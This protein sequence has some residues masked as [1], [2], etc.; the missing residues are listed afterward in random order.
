MSGPTARVPLALLPVRLETRFAGAELLVRIYP[1]AIHVD[2]H[3]PELTDAEA[4]AGRSYWEH[5]WRA[6]SDP[7]REQ[8]AWQLLA[9]RFG[10]ERSAWIARLLR[11]DPAGRPAQPLADEAVLDPAPVFPRPALRAATWTRAPLARAMPSRW[12]AVAMRWPQVDPRDEPPRSPPAEVVTATGTAI[13]RVLPAGPDPD[14]GGRAPAWLTDFAQAELVGMGLRLALTAGMQSQGIHRLLVY[15]LDEDSSADQ[16]AREVAEL[17]D[18]H[19]YSDGLSFLAPGT[20]TNNT[21]TVRSGYDQRGPAYV[22]AYRVAGTD[23]SPSG[24]DSAANLLAGAL[25]VPLTERTAVALRSGPRGLDPHIAEAAWERSL[26]R[27]GLPGGELDDWLEA[28]RVLRAGQAKALAAAAGGA[29]DQ[30]RL[31][32]AMHTALWA[33]TLGYYLSQMLAE[34]SG[35][36][37]RRLDKR[38][39]IAQDAYL[40]YLDRVRG[41][42]D[43][44][45]SAERSVLGVDSSDPHFKSKR[46]AWLLLQAKINME[47]RGGYWAGTP[48][49]DDVAKAGRDLQEAL[50]AKAEESWRAR[51]APTGDVQR[52]WEEAVRNLP[53]SRAERFAYENWLRRR[54]V[55]GEY[56]GHTGEDWAAGETAVAWSE[57]TLRAARRHFVERVRPGGP[58]PALRIGAQPYGVLPILPLDRWTPTAGEE[59]HRPVVRALLALRERVWA[60][61]APRMPQVGAH[62]RQTVPEAQETLLRLLSTSPL[63][64]SLFARQHLGRDYLASLW[65]FARVQLRPDWE[66]VV[67][68][69]SAQLLVDAGVAW[70]PRLASMVAGRA[71]APIAGPLVA[72]QPDGSDAASDLAWLASPDRRWPDLAGRAETGADPHKTPL[73]YRLARQSA[74]RELATGAVRVQLHRGTLGDWEHLDAELIDLRLD[75]DTPTAVRQLARPFTLSDGTQ[76]T[77]GEYVAGPASAADADVEIAEF[78]QAASILAGTPVDRLEQTLRGTLDALSHRLD[79]WLTSYATARLRTLRSAQP[80]GLAVG[81]YGWVEHLV[82]RKTAPISDGYVHAPSLQQAVTAGILRSGY[83]S[84]SGAGKNPFAVNL[85]SE[86]IRTARH[87]LESVRNGQPLGAVAGYLF[88]RALHESGADQYTDDFRR[89]APITA[90]AVDADG[91]APQETVQSNAVADGLSLRAMRREGSAALQTLLQT[92]GAASSTWRAAVEAALQ[93]LDDALDAVADALIAESVHHAASGN[94]ARAAAT[95]DAVARGDGAVPQL[96]FVRTPR[97]GIAITHRVALLTAAAPAPAAGWNVAR[98]GSRAACSP[99]LESIAASLLPAPGRVRCSVRF[100][101]GGR[102]GSTVVRLSQCEVGAL[103]CAYATP[104][105]PEPGH[106]VPALFELGVV[107]VARRRFGLG[108]EVPLVIDWNRAADWADGDLTFA[109]LVASARLVLGLL[110]HARPLR[111]ADLL[112]PEGVTSQPQT[113]DASLTARADDSASALRASLARIV[114]P[115]TVADG[116]RQAV[117]FGAPGAAEAL[118]APAP[119]AGAAA[120]IQAELER[121]LRDLQAAEAPPA[122]GIG[123]DTRRLKAVFGNEYLPSPAIAPADVPDLPA[124]LTFG[125]GLLS[126]QPAAGRRWMQRMARV[127]PAMAALE[128]TRIAGLATSVGAPPQLRVLQLPGVTGEAWVGGTAEVSGTRVNVALLAP[129]GLDPSAPLAGILVDDWVEVLASAKQTTGIAFHFDTPGA[130]APQSILLAV[131]PDPGAESWTPELVEQSVL[132]ALL[133]AKLRTV[134]PEALE[135]V[136]QLF[137][138]L[139]VPNVVGDAAST[140]VLPS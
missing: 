99:A 74:L 3:E 131:A 91:G 36:D 122:E 31:T 20:P 39:L 87:V 117:A 68:L 62:R 140:D 88:E 53:R 104:P 98:S 85:S 55:G 121:R 77:L 127:R 66:R 29:D 126:A 102:A 76:K 15:G 47:S 100:E 86:R 30:E 125:D 124:D 82:P 109:E 67:R 1:D 123:R 48:S 73:L 133:L 16:G 118:I 26:L 92:I 81:G 64:Q 24:A 34:A 110:R 111:A 128:R 105:R 65:R 90:T 132:D 50:S 41:A 113:P 25:G 79:A 58:L 130:Q 51:G 94:P 70:Q 37:A 27:G 46:D 13:P 72:A 43:D 135:E 80:S 139:Y 32:R 136:G 138:A 14:Q 56:W 96:D 114:E 18:A 8:G 103:D 61:A 112:P 75:G 5:I 84:H 108:A 42:V 9:A 19:F 52:D 49:S 129:A 59:G 7:A 57:D 116:L 95:L 134:D 115:S 12:R 137:P 60:P 6:G 71:S 44:W 38:N 69:T 54:D 120:A 107:E 93:S 4:A 45:A 2:T 33:G 106:E 17:I 11:P 83:L 101:A 97:S 35:E 22:E 119:D 40:R 28:E 78:R 63:N 10:P 23:A 89:L 21:E